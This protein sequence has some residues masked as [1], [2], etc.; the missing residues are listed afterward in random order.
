MLLVSPL[1]I[2][3]SCLAETEIHQGQNPAGELI[4]LLPWC[5][6]LFPQVQT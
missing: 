5:M 3:Y 2:N 6:E 4:P 1:K